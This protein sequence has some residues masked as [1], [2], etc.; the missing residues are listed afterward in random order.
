MGSGDVALVNGDVIN[1]IGDEG[2]GVEGLALENQEAVARGLEGTAVV[3]CGAGSVV[4]V[5]APKFASL[6]LL[7]VLQQRRQ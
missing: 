1:D 5:V 6:S 4:V 7:H 3:Y 2:L